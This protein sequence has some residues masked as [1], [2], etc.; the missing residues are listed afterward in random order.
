MMKQFENPA[1]PAIHEQTT[2]PEIWEDTD[3]AVD[4]FVSG[5]G[6]GGHDHRREPVHQEDE[7]QGDPERGG[8]AR[9]VAAHHADPGRPAARPGAAQDPGDRG[10]LRAEEPGPRDGGP[11]GAGVERGV[12]RDGAAPG[13]RG[14]DPLRRLVRRGHG[15]RA[16]ARLRPRLRREDDRD[17]A[18]RLRRALPLRPA[19][20]GPLRR[21]RDDGGLAGQG[22]DRPVGAARA[23]R[24]DA[25]ELSARPEGAARQPP[26]PALARRDPGDR[27][28]PAG[29]VLPGL[30]RPAGPDR[31]EPGLPRRQPALDAAREDREA[32]RDVPLLRGRVRGASP[33]T[34]APRRRGG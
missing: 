29:A 27:E 11:G 15:R 26:L 25:G 13:P 3:G 1:N 9:G 23:R 33:T 18:P 6:T 2:G 28:A 5:V 7:G 34:P 14:G 22:R 24:G 30:L 31:R 16:A 17:R 4:V 12:D 21:G 19:L 8:R 10:E 32:G 20:R